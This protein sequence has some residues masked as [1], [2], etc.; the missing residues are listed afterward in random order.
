MTVVATVR[1][2][3]NSMLIAVTTIVGAVLALIVRGFDH[4]GDTV[5]RMARVWAIAITRMGGVEIVIERRGEPPA[6]PCVYMA[7]H[8]STIDIFALLVALPAPTR[9]I[10]KKQLSYIPI[11]GWAMWAGRFIFIDRADAT[12]ARRSIEMAKQRIRQGQAV[13]IFP[14]GTRS[15]DGRLLP[16]KKGGFHLAVDAGVPIVPCGIR[17]TREL[18][19]RRSL[20]MRPGRVTV[21]V[22]APVPTDGLRLEQRDGLVD[23]V[24]GEIA[25]MIGEPV[26]PP[27]PL[28]TSRAPA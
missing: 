24:R 11:L 2:A 21:V 13:V 5:V 19:P 26:A 28:S 7:N 6:G 23:R 3:L 1:G 27:A 18:M 17:G 14:E 20:L 10:A 15:R 16:F 4:S 25:D 8:L 22:G 12:A 9:M